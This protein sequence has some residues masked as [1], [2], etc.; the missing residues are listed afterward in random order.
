[1]MLLLAGGFMAASAYDLFVGGVQ[2][3]QNGRVTGNTISGSVTYDNSTKTLTL[4]DATISS[5]SANNGISNNGIEDLKIVISGR[6]SIKGAKGIRASKK[7][8][9]TGKDFGS[10]VTI[11]AIETLGGYGI[12][13]DVPN[14]DFVLK[15]YGLG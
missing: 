13:L 12:Y 4:T 7:T 6:C 11:E 2:V 14:V 15:K 8:T 5:S 9:V 10:N 3:M 1:M